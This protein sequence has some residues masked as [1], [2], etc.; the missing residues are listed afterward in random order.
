M[1]EDHQNAGGLDL[2]RAWRVVRSRWWVIVVCALVA[3]AA[4]LGLSLSQEKK[5]SASASLLFRDSRLDQTLFGST[6]FNQEDPNREAATNAKLVSLSVVSTRTANAIGHGVTPGQV[7]S[8]VVV[9]AQGQSNVVSITATDPDPKL[10]ALI[11]NTFAEQYIDFRREADRAK[12][13]DAQSLVQRQLDQLS[14]EQRKSPEGRSLQQRAEQLQILTSLQTGNAELVQSA[15]TPT[16]PSSPNPKRDG[17]LGLLLGL[18]LGGALAFL[19]ERLDRRVKDPAQLS[20]IFGRPI[21][22]AIPES[23]EL[24]A[25]EQEFLVLSSAEAE[26]I[27]MLRANLRYFNVDREIKSVLITSAAPSE[28]KSTVAL[29]L[30]AAAASSGAR[31]VLVEADLRRPT[32]S[33][34]LNLTGS[35]GLSQVLASVRDLRSAID[36][37]H[38]TAKDG[39][40]PLH[41]LPSG[42]I[43]PNPTDLIE[44]D[45]MRQI[46]K[47][48]ERA[49]DLVVIDTPPTSIVSDAIPLVNEVSGVLVVG[50]LGKTTRDSASHLHSQLENLGADVLGVVVNSIGRGTRYGG[51][52]YGYGYG[53]AAEYTARRQPGTSS[54]VQLDPEKQTQRNG[55]HAGN[56]S[57]GEPVDEYGE[58]ISSGRD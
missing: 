47:S 11:P 23:R 49:Y 36:K 21:L 10:A 50:R 22:G 19:L 4:S 9:E 46:I 1:T 39:G 32:M 5:Y 42:P 25:P 41:V 53:Y 52:G 54:T 6:Y 26:P 35:Y 14:P 51:Y 56:G 29:H 43:P 20:E 3:T 13:R 44:S 16:S 48:L 33:V 2:R 37:V 30:A 58:R 18:V 34:R 27:R 45:R 31:V 38:G 40:Q 17:I 24:G 12:V 28:G 7:S 8:E 55:V 15:S 57:N